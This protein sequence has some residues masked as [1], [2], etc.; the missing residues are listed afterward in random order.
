MLPLTILIRMTT[1]ALQGALLGLV[2]LGGL[3]MAVNVSPAIDADG[4][5]PAL[6]VAYFAG[7]STLAAARWHVPF[8]A[9]YLGAI[10][11]P[12]LALW[13]TWR[14]SD[15][16]YV[17]LPWSL[18]VAMALMTAGVLFGKAAYDWAVEKAPTNW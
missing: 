16:G 5:G 2:A 18:G 7:A 17:G 1:R 13:G 12:L 8:R 15:A 6:V 11:G 10:G 3:A 4:L 14:L 9:F